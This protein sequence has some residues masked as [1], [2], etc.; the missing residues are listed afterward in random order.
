MS[1]QAGISQFREIAVLIFHHHVP[2]VR[3]HG[4]GA[5]PLSP[6]VL[7]SHVSFL[8]SI[9]LAFAV[10][11]DFGLNVDHWV[12]AVV[13]AAPAVASRY[14]CRPMF[15]GRCNS[16]PCVL[17]SGCRRRRRATGSAVAWKGTS[18]RSYYCAS[19]NSFC[20]PQA[21]RHQVLLE[22]VSAMG[23][24]STPTVTRCRPAH[25]LAPVRAVTRWYAFHSTCNKYFALPKNDS[26]NG[27]VRVPLRTR[28]FPLPFPM[29]PPRRCAALSASRINATEARSVT[30]ASSIGPTRKGSRTHPRWQISCH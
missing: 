13:V 14:S 30:W 6:R 1:P 28:T 22:Q 9:A 7:Y 21:Q 5:G 20:E 15:A 27:Q 2:H 26:C 8:V 18:R 23:L 24:S 12:I 17:I 16:V 29:A 11:L 25:P 10:A 19:C 3:R 4:V